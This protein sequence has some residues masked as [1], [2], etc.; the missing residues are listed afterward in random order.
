M[1]I[2]DM[3]LGLLDLPGSRYSCVAERENGQILI[4]SGVAAVD[5]AVVLRWGTEATTVLEAAV[6]GGLEDVILTSGY[7]YHLVRPLG[8]SRSLLVYL[9]VDRARANLASARRE[10]AAVRFEDRAVTVAPPR[11]PPESFQGLPPAISHAASAMPPASAPPVR[12]SAVAPTTPAA[13]AVPLPR[14]AGPRAIPGFAPPSQQRWSAD[15]ILGRQ[16]AN[17]VATMSRL[18]TALRAWG[19]DVESP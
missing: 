5:P 8:V 9:C 10:L 17:D 7:L 14:R 12:P 11:P 1:T 13:V 16:W 4:E 3:V 2:R 18:L 6:D 19:D 15:P